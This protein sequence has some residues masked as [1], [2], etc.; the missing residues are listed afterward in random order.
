MIQGW[1]IGHRQEFDMALPYLT[2]HPEEKDAI[3]V[4]DC[5]LQR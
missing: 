3:E 4:G 2:I 5:L 1:K